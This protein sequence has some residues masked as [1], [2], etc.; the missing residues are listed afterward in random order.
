MVNKLPTFNIK[1]AR[2]QAM[3]KIEEFKRQLLAISDSETPQGIDYLLDVLIR[4]MPK[5]PLPDRPS[6]SLPYLGLGYGKENNVVSFRGATS[7]SAYQAKTAIAAPSAPTA[8][9]DKR[10]TPEYHR[11]MTFVLQWEGSKFTDDPADRGGPTRY[12][13]IQVRYDQYRKAKKLPTQS[14]RNITRP[15][16]DEIYSTYYW[17]PVQGWRFHPSVGAAVMDF[18]VNSGPSRSIKYLQRALSRPQTGKLN[19]GD[20]AAANAQNHLKLAQRLIADREAFLR[21]I[22]NGNPSQGK[23][24][25]G[26][27]NRTRDLSKLVKE[28]A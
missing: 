17:V 9:T 3:A 6:G 2:T 21:G 7:S 22:V 8:A 10:L 5:E 1:L 23:F 16:V 25:R 26:W 14:V 28:F 24:L 27:L 11:I 15:E 13:V 12:G 18:G 19:E 4:Q 20:I